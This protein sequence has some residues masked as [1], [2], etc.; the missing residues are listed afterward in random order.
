MKTTLKRIVAVIGI[1]LSFS[2]MLSGIREFGDA[3]TWIDI[4]QGLFWLIVGGFAFTGFLD[5]FIEKKWPFQP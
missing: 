4:F 5:D 1:I 3:T 2:V